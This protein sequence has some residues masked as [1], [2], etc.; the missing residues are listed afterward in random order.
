MINI[1]KDERVD[2]IGFG[3]LKLIQKP[4]EFCYGVDAVILADFAAGLCK[5]SQVVFDLGT[6]TGVIPMIFN[7]KKSSGKIYGVEVQEGSAKRA[8]RNVQLNGLQEK[9]EIIHS[10]IKDLD[11][12]LWGT[13]DVVISN[14]PY[15]PHGGALKNSNDAKTIARHEITAN[16]E[17]FFQVA[18]KL[19]K[20]KGELFMVHRPSRLADLM[21]YGRQYKLEA[22][23]VQMVSPKAGEAPNIVLVHF[24]KNGG[25]EIKMMPNLNVHKHEGGYT[26]EILHI[27]EKE[28]GNL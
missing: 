4:K 8:V 9:I 12:G 10:N 28:M 2:E 27:Y 3:N 17:D 19:L 23:S 24:A 18:A 13:A 5:R 16:L 20:E 26:D 1:E 15:F 7:Y 21:C 11:N 25:K 6:G 14:P 22:K